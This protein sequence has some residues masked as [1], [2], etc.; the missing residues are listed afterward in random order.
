[1]DGG[2]RRERQVCPA[3]KAG[4]TVAHNRVTVR[5]P[6]DESAGG[7]SRHVARTN[8]ANAARAAIERTTRDQDP[9]IV[10]S[11]ISNVGQAT[12]DFQ[13]RSFPIAVIDWSISSEFPATVTPSTGCV[14]SP[15]SIQ[16]PCAWN[17]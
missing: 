15:F 7:R 14:S 12:E 13:V 17:E 1:M 2:A 9:L 6:R 16:C 11:E 8:S 5:A 4:L 3:T 10:I